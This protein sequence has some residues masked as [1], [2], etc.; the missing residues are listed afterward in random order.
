M[1]KTCQMT[2]MVVQIL[3]NSR[4]SHSIIVAFVSASVKRNILSW[5]PR[6]EALGEKGCSREAVS[7]LFNGQKESQVVHEVRLK[8]SSRRS[9]GFDR[10]I[11][12]RH[13]RR[14]DRHESLC[15]QSFSTYARSNATP[16]CTRSATLVHNLALINSTHR[17]AGAG[18]GTVPLVQDLSHVRR[19][20][21]TESVRR[22]H[23]C[24]RNPDSMGVGNILFS[25]GRFGGLGLHE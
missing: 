17:P 5:M 14:R 24:A 7:A 9:S 2:D 4:R 19:L 10:D 23:A 18:K 21:S 8:D 25:A 12:D 16:P 3:S 6:P 1:A 11:E 15:Y 20:D 22:Q 13:A